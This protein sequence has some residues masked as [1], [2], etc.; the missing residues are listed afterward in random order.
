MPFCTEC[1]KE[2]D[3]ESAFCVHCGA[4]LLNVLNTEQVV[5]K[6]KKSAKNNFPQKKHWCLIRRL[7][8]NYLSF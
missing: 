6:L 5:G 7:N 1:G 3:N 2:N 8:T 4:K